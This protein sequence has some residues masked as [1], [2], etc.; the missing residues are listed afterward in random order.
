M[1]IGWWPYCGLYS[2]GSQH[3]G[4]SF[5]HIKG[6]QIWNQMYSLTKIAP[7][8]LCSNGWSHYSCNC[9]NERYYCW[10]D[11][12]WNSQNSQGRFQQMSLRTN[13]TLPSFNTD[14]KVYISKNTTTNGKVLIPCQPDSPNPNCHICAD[15][16]TVSIHYSN[17]LTHI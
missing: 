4:L 5:Q 17:S 2:F 14:I 10:F 16:L 12:R 1:Q 13:W 6:N 3:S 9:H 8:P 11:G 15:K 7:N